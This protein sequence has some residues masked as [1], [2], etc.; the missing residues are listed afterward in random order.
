MDVKP[1]SPPVSP[2][3]APTTS[4][5]AATFREDMSAVEVAAWLKREGIPEQ[6]C[7][8]FEGKTIFFYSINFDIFV[9]CSYCL[10]IIGGLL[11]HF[12]Y[13]HSNPKAMKVT[14]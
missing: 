10:L 4:P 2:A 13:V 7:R 8:S 12:A 14:L 9:F 5:A 3:Y 11:K 1:D 6:Y